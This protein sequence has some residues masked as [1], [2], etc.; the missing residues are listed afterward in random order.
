MNVNGLNYRLQDGEALDKAHPQTFEIP[1]RDDRD[2]LEPGAMVKLMFLSPDG[3]S[4]S[5]M[6]E[7]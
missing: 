1:D 7:R 2:G 4:S 6:W 5:H 3:G